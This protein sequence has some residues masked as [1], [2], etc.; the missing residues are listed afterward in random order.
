MTEILATYQQQALELLRRARIMPVLSLDSVEQGLACASALAEG[1]LN[2]I[3]VTLRTAAALD[4]IRAIR[5][6]GLPLSVGA[7]TVLDANQLQAAINHG[8]EFIITPGTPAA[9]AE[10]L[11]NAPLPVI[12]GAA[13]ATEA[14][15]LRARGFRVLKFFPAAACGGVNALKALHG[16]FP[17]LNFCPTGGIGERDAKDYLALPNVPCVGGSWMVRKE[18]LAAG[19]WTAV[20]ASANRA[21]GG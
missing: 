21:L 12:P 2:A 14:M 5:D 11:Q 3:E 10:A 7:G 18:W 1:G 16:P 8:A 20:S 15:A 9:L 17:D 19:D 6:A 4:A 13:T